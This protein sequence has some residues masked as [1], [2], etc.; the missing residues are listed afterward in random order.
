MNTGTA[1]SD[2]GFWWPGK[3]NDGAMGWAFMSAKSGP[4]WIR[5]DV[6]RGA[7]FYDGEADLG[8]G[9]AFRMAA[10]VLADD[11]LF[12]WTAY[13][14][15]LTE[16]NRK[17]EVVPRD[18]I[19]SRFWIVDSSGSTGIE[20]NRDGFMK[21]SPVIWTERTGTI[22]FDIE[23]RSGDRH[24]TRIAISSPHRWDIINNGKKVGEYTPGDSYK[25]VEI[26]G[27]SNSITLKRKR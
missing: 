25:E 17:K 12:G 20:L 14:G 13:G 6:D 27:N 18:G 16:G 22:E 2:Y 26:S 7:W 11:P 19:R 4:A 1:E 21:E 5:K 24:T 9:A 15:T 23:N 3:E 8:L 10:T